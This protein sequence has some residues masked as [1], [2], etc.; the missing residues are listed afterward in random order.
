MNLQALHPTVLALILLLEAAV[1]AK[2]QSTI[3]QNNLLQNGGFDSGQA[4]WSVT[5]SASDSDLPAQSLR[6]S[7]LNPPAG[8]AINLTN[9]LITWRPAI[10][11]SPATN[12]LTVVVADD[13]IP[14][15]SDTQSFAVMLLRPAQPQ[16]LI[17]GVINGSFKLSVSGDAGP[18]YTIET[19]PDLTP[20]VEWTSVFTNHSATPPFQWTDHAASNE[21]QRF[22]RVRLSP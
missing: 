22:Y 2:A 20:P 13:G 18:D 1:S 16:A 5:N 15:M 8:A 21:L 10:W 7:L 19:A 4:P 9:G 11:Q 6:W 12:T 14:G 17:A 3:T